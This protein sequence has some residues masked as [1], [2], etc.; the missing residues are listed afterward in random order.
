MKTNEI[1]NTQATENAETLVIKVY[2]EEKT[3]QDGRKFTAYKTVTKNGR[4][5]TCKFRKDVKDL[6]TE[7]A[8]VTVSIDAMNMQKDSE[9]PT[10]WV[11]AIESWE[12]MT[13]TVDVEANRKAIREIF[14]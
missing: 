9:Y 5:I 4:K 6:P 1:K 10:L 11:S 12:P 3:T 14:N 8:L 7:N 2:V 13:T